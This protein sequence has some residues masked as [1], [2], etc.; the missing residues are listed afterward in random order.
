MNVKE[1]NVE[2]QTKKQLAFVA[3]KL[4]KEGYKNIMATDDGHYFTDSDLAKAHAKRIDS[5]VFHFTSE[6]FEPASEDGQKPLDGSGEIT[7]PEEVDIPKEVI[8]P[9]PEAIQGEI[10]YPEPQATVKPKAV[11]VSG[12]VKKPAAKQVSKPKTK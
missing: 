1:K 3:G 7:G 11:K 9:E 4:V 6:D 2:K 8:D 5:E 12:P 10:I